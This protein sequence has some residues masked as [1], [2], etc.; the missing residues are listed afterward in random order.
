MGIITKL[1]SPGSPQTSVRVKTIPRDT[2][3]GQNI[4][5]SIFATPDYQTSKIIVAP[6]LFI[7]FIQNV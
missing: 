4:H 3:A 1:T 6:F 7:A 2:R 5:R